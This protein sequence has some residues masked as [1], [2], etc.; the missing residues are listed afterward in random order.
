VVNGEL[1]AVAAAGV[2]DQHTTLL[3]AA[4]RLGHWVASGAL[5]ETEARAALTTAAHHF[6]GVE[7]YTAARIARDITDGLAYGARHPRRVEDIPERS[8]PGELAQRSLTAG[9]VCSTPSRVSTPGT[10]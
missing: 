10:T 6:V 5:A 3:R 2:G 4:R 9:W 7:G 1:A 8:S